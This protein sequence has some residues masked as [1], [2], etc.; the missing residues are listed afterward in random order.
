MNGM[1][2]PPRVNVRVNV[3]NNPGAPR[4]GS[5]VGGAI[6]ITLV[7]AVALTIG[8]GRYLAGAA[9]LAVMAVS[10]VLMVRARRR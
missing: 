6:I 8:G 10:A 4:R 7:A 2:E 9:A 1:S 3:T 5:V